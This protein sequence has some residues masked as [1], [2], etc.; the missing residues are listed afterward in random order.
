MPKILVILLWRS[1]LKTALPAIAIFACFVLHSGL[2]PIYATHHNNADVLLNTIAMVSPVLSGFIAWDIN[3]QKRHHSLKDFRVLTARSSF[4][5]FMLDFLKTLIYAF[6]LYVVMFIFVTVRGLIVFASL[7][8]G[9]YPLIRFII[10]LTLLLFFAAFAAIT[11]YLIKD[12]AAVLVAALPPLLIYGTALIYSGKTV[13][14]SLIPFGSRGA[15]HYSFSVS[16]FFL[17][18]EISYLGAFGLLLALFML[19]CARKI[20]VSL[21]LFA[22]SCGTITGGVYAMQ[23]QGG[24]FLIEKH[25]NELEYMEF[26]NAENTIKIFANPDLQPVS[27]D[28]L[29]VWE[30]VEFLTRNTPMHVTKLYQDKPYTEPASK[31]TTFYESSTGKDYVYQTVSA[32]FQPFLLKNCE[33]DNSQRV[34][35]ELIVRF[36]AGQQ[37][38]EIRDFGFLQEDAE[39]YATLMSKNLEE[40]QKWFT[41]NYEKFASCTIELDD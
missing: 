41:K 37:L 7:P 34:Y 38:E 14:H 26:S 5:V 40:A 31:V 25:T 10:P 8:H 9:E 30:R 18:Q 21:L 39:K 16:E 22:I 24:V 1:I 29:K 13:W 32:S 6:L 33:P 4:S 35:T 36:L 11:G 27:T 15:T 19:L 12:W 3:Q 23:N 28:L 17:I 20:L 2:N